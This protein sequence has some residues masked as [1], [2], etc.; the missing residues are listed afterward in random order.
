MLSDTI[1]FSADCHLFTTILKLQGKRYK[2][3]T[4]LETPADTPKEMVYT[5]IN[6]VLEIKFLVPQ[7]IKKIKLLYLA[8]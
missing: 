2:I 7:L 4:H 6:P 1:S 3:N 8:N 5:A